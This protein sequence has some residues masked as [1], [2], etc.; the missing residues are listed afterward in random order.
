MAICQIFQTQNAIEMM[1]NPKSVAVIGAGVSGLIAAIELEKAGFE[2]T[3]YDGNNQ[4]GGRVVSIEEEN[5]ILDRG[6]Q[7]MLTAYPAV[8]KYLD[9]KALK[10]RKFQPGAL[11]YQNGGA[12][13]FGDPL[14]KF[15]FALSTLVAPFAT[16]KDKWNVFRLRN[17]VLK[18]SEDEIF[19]SP[20]KTTIEYL[21]DYGFSNQIIDG[22]F[23]PFYGG[24]FLEDDLTT[25]SRMFLFVFKMFS[26][27]SA[28][29][30]E[31]GIGAISEQLASRI[32]GEIRLGQKVIS[33][34]QTSL[35]TDSGIEESYDAIILA[36]VTDEGVKWHGCRNL[37]FKTPVSSIRAPLI[38]L[39]ADENTWINNLH[40]PTDLKRKP[41]KYPEW[42]VLSVTVLNHLDVADETLVDRVKRELE[43]YCGIEETEFLYL[44]DIPKALPVLNDLKYAPDEADI[45][46]TEP[47]VYCIGDHTANASLNAAMLSGAK[48]AELLIRD[49]D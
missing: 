30:P 17:E 16:I 12:Y 29:V 19:A 31:E 47:R 4:V 2:V 36:H 26:K 44:F 45:R 40:F 34:N 42:S 22:F 3:I 39:V 37:Y 41:P 15:G 43:N 46:S 5:R 14:R 27:G 35:Q 18:M 7:V 1:S 48:A 13:R 25:S 24:I 20:E 23:K 32:N 49:F 11:V 33:R 38:G 8:Q 9:L 10:L 28:A 6:F 21:R